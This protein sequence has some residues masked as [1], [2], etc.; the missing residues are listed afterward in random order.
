MSSEGFSRETIR[1]VLLEVEELEDISKA[2][3]GVLLRRSWLESW[4]TNIWKVLGRG[5]SKILIERSLKI[6][7]NSEYST[8][9][10]Y[11]AFRSIPL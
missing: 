4:P 8:R 1:G 10:I 6:H 9:I 5:T 7:S 3:D 11:Q 2:G